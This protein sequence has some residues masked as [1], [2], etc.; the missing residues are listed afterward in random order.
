MKKI[1]AKI[2]NSTITFDNSGIITPKKITITKNDIAP[3]RIMYNPKDFLQPLDL[4]GYKACFDYYVPNLDRTKSFPYPVYI[5]NDLISICSNSPQLNLYYTPLLF[6][7]GKIQET[8][9]RANIILIQTGYNTY[10]ESSGIFFENT[11]DGDKTVAQFYFG[12]K[13]GR[14][15]TAPLILNC[16]YI[17]PPHYIDDTSF[18]NHYT[19]FGG[20]MCYF[21]SLYSS[22]KL[23]NEIIRYTFLRVPIPFFVIFSSLEEYENAIS[24]VYTQEPTVMIKATQTTETQ[25]IND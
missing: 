18:L 14:H 13:D 24:L 11:V 6:P 5:G 15:V 3:L 21:C 16:R 23:D 10:R 17:F 12:D 1:D 8:G 2:D 22:E 7:E 25:D 9:S 20:A 19:E 4:A